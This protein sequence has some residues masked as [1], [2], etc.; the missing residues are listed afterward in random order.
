MLLIDTDPGLDDAHALAM[1]LGSR[2][3]EELLITTVAGNVGLD[4]V[5]HN[6]RRIVG[7]LSPR[8]PIFAGAAG[9]LVG[10]SIVA[11]HIHGA[12]GMAGFAWGETRLA[13]LAEGSAATAIVDAARRYGRELHIVALGPLTNLA[14]ALRLEPALPRLVGSVTAMGGSPRMLGNAS[15]AAEFNVFADPVAASIV[16]SS[17]PLTLVTWDLTLEH[18]APAAEVRGLWSSATPAAELLR[19]ID[20]HR[21]QNDAAYAERELLGRVDPLAMA[22]AMDPDIVLRADHHAVLV[23]TAGGAAHGATIVDWQDATD[24]PRLTLP[25]HLDEQRARQRMTL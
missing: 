16:F 12:D 18:R 11:D 19:A 4:V 22:I 15:V 5:T 21:V 13:P 17:M 14:L 8:T 25:V 1:A 23:D 2:P 3:P 7:A 6:A 24:L 9:P 20:D 10:S